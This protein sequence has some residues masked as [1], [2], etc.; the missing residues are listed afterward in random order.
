VTQPAADPVLYDYNDYCAVSPGKFWIITDGGLSVYDTATWKETALTKDANSFC[1]IDADTLY[2]N[3]G[4]YST[5]SDL[6]AVSL[7]TQKSSLV[8]KKVGDCLY[9]P[10][11]NVLYY[12][13]DDGAN[14]KLYVRDLATGKDTM[15]PVTDPD[16]DQPTDMRGMDFSLLEDGDVMLSWASGGDFEIYIDPQNNATLNNDDTASDPVS[17]DSGS[18]TEDLGNGWSYTYGQ[19][20]LNKDGKLFADTDRLVVF[21]GYI[22]YRQNNNLYRVKMDS[23]APE[24]LQSQTK[25]DE[26]AVFDGKL[27]GTALYSN[28]DKA[29]MYQLNEDG[30][31]AKNLLELPWTNFN[32]LEL[33]ILGDFLT[34]EAI[35]D[36]GSWSAAAVIADNKVV[37][38]NSAEFTQNNY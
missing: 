8:M 22:Y 23:E 36:D 27:Y 17:D 24:L 30:T 19:Y 2:Y 15:I 28:L 35:G 31:T 29:I 18:V 10:D 9:V 32:W 7:K 21:D 11:R 1:G 12:V 38:D 5:G 20:T 34:V 14:G 33:A 13:K 4:Y 6:Y 3:T 25:L 26:M 16:P 37:I